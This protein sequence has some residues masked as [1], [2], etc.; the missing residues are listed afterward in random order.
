MRGNWKK[1]QVEIW[2]ANSTSKGRMPKLSLHFSP[3]NLKTNKQTNKTKNK[4]K[5]KTTKIHK[6]TKPF[7]LTLMRLF[8]FLK[9]DCQ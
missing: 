8:V 4:N 6:K 1:M 5:Q 3:S 2:E 9:R 7:S